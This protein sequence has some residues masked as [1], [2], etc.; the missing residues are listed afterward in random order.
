MLAWLAGAH[1]WLRV[2]AVLTVATA[3]GWAAWEPAVKRLRERGLTWVLMGVSSFLT[4]IAF[5]WGAIEP[6]L[7]AALQA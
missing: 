4:V 3:W 7:M 6:Q 5:F 1:T 2:V